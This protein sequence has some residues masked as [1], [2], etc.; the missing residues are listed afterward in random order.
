MPNLT[1]LTTPAGFNDAELRRNSTTS[2]MS[3]LRD[4]ATATAINSTGTFA[5]ISHGIAFSTKYIYRTCLGFDLSGNDDDGSSI[6]GNTV[7]SANLVIRS[8][9]NLSG[10][11]SVLANTSNNIYV[12]KSNDP[13]SSW[14][15]ASFGNIDGRPSSGSYD[16]QV[17]VYGT[18]NEAANSSISITLNSTCI[19]DINSKIGSGGKLLIILLCEDDFLFI[20]STGGLGTP[21]GGTGFF[22]RFEGIR[23]RTTNYATDTTHQPRLEL[24]YGTAAATDNATFF[25]ANF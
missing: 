5:N 1:A 9:P 8:M 23:I 20:T 13:G 16:G 15:T 25:G 17:T 14:D 7:T 12:C 21:T 10:F 6:S 24:T 18:A 19:S 3:T 4:S 22:A 2:D 11:S